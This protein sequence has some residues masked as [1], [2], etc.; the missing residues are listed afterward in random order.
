MG[1]IAVSV[2]F[3]RKYRLSFWK[4]ADIFIP[5]VAL[6]HVFAKIGCFSAGCCYGSPA[7]KNFLLSVIYPDDPE[8]LAPHGIPLYPNQLMEG[9][10]MIGVFLILLW[11]RKKKK[12]DGQVL[13]LYLILY[14]L[15][16]IGLDF[17]RG[18]QARS[19]AVGHTLSVAQILSFSFIAISV[20]IWVVRSRRNALGGKS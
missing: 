8:C 4:V 20:I 3:L 19:F 1:G 6:G 18:N 10:A 9:A 5:G 17:L 12:F 7:P 2:W 11:F 15:I 16:R 13:L 14:S